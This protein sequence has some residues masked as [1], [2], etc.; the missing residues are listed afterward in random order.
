D[1]GPYT[2]VLLRGLARPLKDLPRQ[3]VLQLA[4]GGKYLEQPAV[5]PVLSPRRLTRFL[6]FM[7]LLHSVPQYP[8]SLRVSIPSTQRREYHE[9]DGRSVDDRRGHVTAQISEEAERRQSPGDRMVG[10][11]VY[12]GLTCKHAIRGSADGKVLASVT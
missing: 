2:H 12:E 4:M 5:F 7:G 10:R 6:E 3:R 1:F 11:V 9:R 8:G